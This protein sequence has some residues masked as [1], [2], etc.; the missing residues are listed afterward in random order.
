M[1]KKSL[2][3][4]TVIYRSGDEVMVVN[5]TT[6]HDFKIGEY[7]VLIGKN[8][9]KYWSAKSKYSGMQ[10]SVAD[11]DIEPLLQT[12]DRIAEKIAELKA[13]L[14]EYQEKLNYLK[15]EK[16]TEVDNIEFAAWSLDKKLSSTKNSKERL[17]LLRKS[18]ESIENSKA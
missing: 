15:E 7:I 1:A 5:N 9:N 11:A 17:L 6:G 3:A 16:L 2:K 4:K 14:E 13:E 8:G 10:W 18:L 12:A